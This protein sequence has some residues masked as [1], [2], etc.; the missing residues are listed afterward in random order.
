MTLHLRCKICDFLDVIHY[1]DGKDWKCPN[2]KLN[3]PERSKREDK[4]DHSNCNFDYVETLCN[5][6]YKS[7][8]P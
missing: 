4:N 2:C 7:I 8:H 5:D 6:C 1:E 3:Q